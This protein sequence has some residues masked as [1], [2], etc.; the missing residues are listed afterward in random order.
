[1]TDTSPIDAARVRKAASCLSVRERAVLALSAAED[2]G[3]KA[4]AERLGITLGEAESVLADAI[5]KLDRALHGSER[6]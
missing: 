3:I 6:N 4:I 1:M 2:L 5:C